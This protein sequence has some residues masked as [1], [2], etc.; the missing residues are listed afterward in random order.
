[1]KD[2]HFNLKRR[3]NDPFQTL[4]RCPVFYNS[5]DKSIHMKHLDRDWNSMGANPVVE[6]PDGVVEPIIP[7]GT[8]TLPMLVLDTATVPGSSFTFTT[9]ITKEKCLDSFTF[10]ERKN[11]YKILM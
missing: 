9:G 3:G 4:M 5:G 7:E 6:T 2:D 10:N 8:P 11:E 1:M